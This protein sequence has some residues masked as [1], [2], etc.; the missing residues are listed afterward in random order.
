MMKYVIVGFCFGHTFAMTI[1]TMIFCSTIAVPIT[2]ATTPITV[3][4]S[5][6][7]LYIGMV[8]SA[9]GSAVEYKVDISYVST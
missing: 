1:K 4:V 9:N 8:G 3:L 7:V 2:E 6:L 5:E